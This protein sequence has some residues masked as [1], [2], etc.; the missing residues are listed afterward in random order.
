MV[1]L[2]GQGA[3]P[4]G[5]SRRRKGCDYDLFQLRVRLR[6]GEGQVPRV[7]GAVGAVLG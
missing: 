2:F 6:L 5:G 1:R 7:W 4:G 3:S